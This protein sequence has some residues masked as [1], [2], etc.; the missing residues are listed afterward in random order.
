M[1]ERDI[2][3]SVIIPVY[4]SENY[5]RECLDSVVRQ[6]LKEIEII[7]VDDGSADNS[8]N[9]LHEYEARDSRIRVYEQIHADAGTARN[10][11]LSL[12]KGEYLAILDSDDFFEPDMLERA[13][14]KAAEQRTEIVVFGADAFNEDTSSF[15]ELYHTIREENLPATTV[16]S[17]REIKREL[18]ST[19]VGWTWDKLF[20]RKYIKEN[21]IVFQEQ[22]TTNDLRFTFTALAGAERISIVN[23]VLAHH[24]THIKTSLEATREKSYQCFYYALIGLQEE[25][26]KKSLY[27]LLEQD[28]INYCLYFCLENLEAMTGETKKEM[29]GRL[30]KEWFKNLGITKYPK[31][32]YYHSEEYRRF[33][34]IMSLR[35]YSYSFVNKHILS[36]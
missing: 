23:D 27:E 10:K 17:S 1:S 25:L 26:K 4:N 2:C 5:L 29:Y 22:R 18:F 3:V 12:A 31:K 13:Y 9:I 15:E 11:G 7:A 19:F 36:T 33:K 8:L 20:Q 28:Y 6:T 35:F 21:D 34:L 14:A 32:F 24:R 16:F 30:R